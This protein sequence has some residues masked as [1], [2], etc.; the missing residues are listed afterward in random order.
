[1]KLLYQSDSL[2]IWHDPKH[3][4]YADWKG[5][6]Y[7]L[8][9]KADS[10][11]LLDVVE[12]MQCERVLLDT[13]HIKGTWLQLIPW[14]AKFY[15]PVV[16][17]RGVKKVAFLYAVGG[18]GQRSMER[19]VEVNK[20]FES[21]VFQDYKSA[22]AWLQGAEFN[23]KP[24]PGQH[25]D[26]LVIQVK[27][28][29]LV[30]PFSNVQYVYSH[31][32]GTALQCN[33]DLLFTDAALKEVASKLPANF[34]QIHRSYIVDIERILSIKHHNSGS[35]HLFLKDIPN[36]MLPV[37]KSFVPMLKQLLNI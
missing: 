34:V 37:S 10:N 2:D 21:H 13:R 24:V 1:M 19:T 18:F 11:H 30:V 8:R 29:H 35:Y 26:R 27:D 16:A 15:F 22:E 9:V 3:F 36:V 33:D 20:Y 12:E 5:Y 32:K 28:Q 31:N 23:E 25:K 4:I 7:P 14:F 6:A 17:K